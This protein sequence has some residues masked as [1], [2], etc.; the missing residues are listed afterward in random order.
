MIQKPQQHLVPGPVV[1]INE[2]EDDPYDVASDEEEMDNEYNIA[3]TPQNDVGLMLALSASRDDLVLRS[4]TTFLNEPNVLSSYRPKYTASPLMD[5]KTARIFCHFITAT[6]PSLSI[7]ER[8]PTNTSLMFTGAPIPSSQQA[9]WTYTLPMLAIS[10]Q[11][12]LHAMLALA[13]L[14]IAKLQNTS[15]TSSLSH[16]QFAIRRIAKA[17]ATP[18]KRTNIATIA[19]TLILSFYEAS[20]AEHSKWNSHLT[21]ARQ[22]LMEVDFRGMTKRIKEEKARAT[23][24]NLYASWQNPYNGFTNYSDFSNNTLPQPDD[25]INERLVSQLMGWKVRFDEYGRVIDENVLEEPPKVQITSKDIETYRTYGDLFW[26][27]CK[28]DVYQ[29]IISGNRLL[30]GNT[31]CDFELY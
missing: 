14:H 29:S 7:F 24:N 15:M 30:Y 28:Q 13:S 4:Y 23:A 16:Y 27:Y 22:L 10:D 3:N 21:G 8:H 19:A 25:N 17:V 9:L 11:P 20:T 5:S 18:S 31:S 26:W 12:L 6:G 1:S 2:V